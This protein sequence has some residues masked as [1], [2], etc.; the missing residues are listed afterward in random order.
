M[1]TIKEIEKSFN[2]KAHVTYKNNY[3]ESD[4]KE[5]DVFVW[6]NGWVSMNYNNDKKSEYFVLSNL[7]RKRLI[8]AL[9]KGL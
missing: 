1:K 4:F 5:L 3:K 6:V 7:N 2:P 8:K 9:Q